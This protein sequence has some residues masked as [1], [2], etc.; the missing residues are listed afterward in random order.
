MHAYSGR[1]QGWRWRIC[2][3]LCSQFKALPQRLGAHCRTAGGTACVGHWS[4][5][6]LWV[7]VS[8]ASLV[9]GVVTVLISLT[10][11]FPP[12][13]TPRIPPTLIFGILWIFEGHFT[14]CQ[15]SLLQAEAVGD[16][17][18]DSFVSG[19]GQG[20]FDPSMAIP[21]YPRVFLEAFLLSFPSPEEFSFLPSSCSPFI[22]WS[23]R[24]LVMR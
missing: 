13:V 21:G 6:C 11:V 12:L 4:A 19:E 18:G 22:F 1:Q 2:F 3:C 15:G 14:C 10:I 7:G 9:Y 8:Y 23:I 16:C 17:S 5:L 20:C 24:L